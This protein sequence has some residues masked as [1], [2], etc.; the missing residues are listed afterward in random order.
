MFNRLGLRTFKCFRD[1][2]LPLRPLT[3]LSGDNASGKSSVLQAMALLHQTVSGHEWSLRLLLNADDTRLGTIADVAD[4]VHGGHSFGIS[5]SAGDETVDW[6]FAGERDSPAGAVERVRVGGSEYEAPPALHYLLPPE[7]GDSV[8]ARRLR[9]LTYLTAERSGPRDSYEFREPGPS[10]GVGSRGERTFRVLHR[11]ED[12]TVV[13]GLELPDAPPTLSR[14]AQAQMAR[15]FP[16]FAFDLG[17][18]RSADTVTPGFRTTDDS[19]FHRPVHAGFGLTQVL[20]IVVAV[21]FSPEDSCLLIENPE[22]HLHPAGQSS[23]GGFLARAVAA[24]LQVVLET[25]SDHVLNGIRRAVRDS[26]LTPDEVALHFFRPRHEA[27]RRG[28][29]QVMTPVLDR[30]GGVDSW[31]AGFFDQFDRD[32]SHLAGWNRA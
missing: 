20:P 14:Q 7:T 5:V 1:L 9:E 31:P 29:A 11:N 13:S 22:V 2:E 26:V 28:E 4:Q 21:L 23:M 24:G 17:K 10:P 32:L 18:T 8:V 27:E 16:G 19:D 12:R 6:D 15:F 3:L 30:D 25:H